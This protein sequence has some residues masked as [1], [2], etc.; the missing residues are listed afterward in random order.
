MVAKPART[1]T[2]EFFWLLHQ[3]LGAQLYYED[4]LYLLW[5]YLH[6]SEYDNATK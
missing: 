1:I 5:K 3:L 2:K 4:Y 6:R